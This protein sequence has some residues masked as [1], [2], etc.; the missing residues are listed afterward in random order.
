MLKHR[1]YLQTDAMKI[2]H[3]YIGDADRNVN[4]EGCVNNL[5]LWWK[6]QV[7]RRFLL[8]LPTSYNESNSNPA[9]LLFDFHGFSLQSTAT[10]NY[11][12]FLATLV[13]LHFTPV[14]E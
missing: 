14:S 7:V 6:I 5:Y 1:F 10:I 13:A 8:F 11:R 2:Y 3:Q 9:P 4:T 12:V